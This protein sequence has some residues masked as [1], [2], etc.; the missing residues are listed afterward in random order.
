MSDDGRWIRQERWPVIFC[1]AFGLNWQADCVLLEYIP[2]L[3]LDVQVG[4]SHL[5][6]F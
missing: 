4:I 5:D 6:V 1:M 3:I 2:P